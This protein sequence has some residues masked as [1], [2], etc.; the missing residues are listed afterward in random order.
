MT[1][2]ISIIIVTYNSEDEILGCLDSIFQ[3][4]TPAIVYVVDNASQDETKNILQ[5]YAEKQPDLKLIFNKDNMGLAFANN[6]PIPFI[7]TPYTLVLNPD[8]IM[9]KDTISKM[10]TKMK[11]DPKLGMIGPLCVFGDGEKHTSA[12]KYYNLFTIIVWRVI[13]HTWVRFFNDRYASYR[14]E[15]VLFVSGACYIIPTALYKQLGGYDPALFLTVADVAELGVRIRQAG[16]K[17]LFYPDAVITHFTNAKLTVNA[18]KEVKYWLQYWGMTGD[19]YYIRKHTGKFAA[20]MLRFVLSANCLMRSTVH[21]VM[22]LLTRKE[23]Q[24][25]KASIFFDLSKSL[26]RYPLNG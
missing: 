8:I 6:Q 21:R 9:R 16:F 12:H 18:E 14:E 23:S 2:E 10:L 7:D 20:E 4:D 15:E 19:L 3:G 24:R 1:K 26:W 13:P 5:K 25:G 22:L 11:G 17:A